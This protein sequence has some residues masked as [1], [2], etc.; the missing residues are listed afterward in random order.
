[1]GTLS[2]L[3]GLCGKPDA[4]EWRGRM[5]A[6]LGAEAATASRRARLAGAFNRGFVG[7]EATYHVCTPSAELVIVRSLA[8]GDRLARDLST[9]FGGS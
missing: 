7:Y 2:F 5:N 4:D 9:R 1:M 6:L 3:R 8:E